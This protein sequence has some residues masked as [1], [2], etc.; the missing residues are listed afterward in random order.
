MDILEEA[1]HVNRK[2]F[3]AHVFSTT[4]EGKAEL[5][6][7]CQYACLGVIPIVILNKLIQRFIPE[8]DPEKSST[9]ITIEVFLQ[10]IAM[11][12]GIIFIHRIIS[13]IPTYSGFNYENLTLTNAVLAF[14]IVVLSIQTKLGI[15]VNILAERLDEMWNGPSDDTSN[16]RR[17]TSNH[18]ISQADYSGNSMM[19]NDIFPPAPIISSNNSK[20]NSSYNQTA[21]SRAPSVEMD[22]GPMPAN[23]MGSSFGTFY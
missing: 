14:M 23:A 18:V 17:Q 3:L 1:R 19:Q 6:N 21:S 10:I 12:C 13:Y 4:E 20:S 9:E 15:K 2:S 11:F 22:V 16:S 7:V 5:L 8:A